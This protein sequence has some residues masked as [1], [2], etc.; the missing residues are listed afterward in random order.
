[1]KVLLQHSIWYTFIVDKDRKFR[2]LFE[3]V[4]GHTLKI[5]LYPTSGGNHD[6]IMVERFNAFLNK[7]SRI[8]CSERDI[9]HAFVEGAQ[10]TAY[11]WNSAPMAETD[12]SRFLVA[13]GRE[14]QF[15]IDFI[16]D[17][18]NLEI[19]DSKISYANSLQKRLQCCQEV[20][21]VLIDEHRCMHR[22]YVNARRVVELL[23][24]VIPAS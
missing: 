9:T 11:A 21:K 22:E 16:R 20:Y 18:I 4:I 5:N 19:L 12:I 14:F 23:L 3:K 17:D 6:A 2:S 8:L 10:L 15:P 1:M 7:S 13:V 24:S